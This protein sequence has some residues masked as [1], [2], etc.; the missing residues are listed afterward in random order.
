MFYFLNNNQTIRVNSASESV[1][2]KVAQLCPSFCNPMNYTLPDFSV[3][4]LL[5][6][7]ILE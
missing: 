2:V 4:G 6:A 1:K 5:Q 3:H 7:R